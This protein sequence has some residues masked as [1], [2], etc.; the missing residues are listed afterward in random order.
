[1]A[2][3]SDVDWIRVKDWRYAGS[4]VDDYTFLVNYDD[5][6]GV[7]YGI[8]LNSLE[9]SI[10]WINPNSELSQ[11]INDIN[12][13]NPRLQYLNHIWV[14][15]PDLI[16]NKENVQW[17]YSSSGPPPTIKP[18]ASVPALSPQEYAEVLPAFGSF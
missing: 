10:V 9:S 11:V 17:H 4:T 13:G 5:E 16:K 18:K 6:G 3:V 14:Y 1:M 12:F 7:K 15:V 2:S 8:Y